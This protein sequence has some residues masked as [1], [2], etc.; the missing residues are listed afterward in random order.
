LADEAA[1]ADRHFLFS[2]HGSMLLDGLVRTAPLSRT[3]ITNGSLQVGT[4]QPATPQQAHEPWGFL[5]Q[6]AFPEKWQQHKRLAQ[7]KAAARPAAQ[8]E[9]VTEVRRSY[10][11]CFFPL[12]LVGVGDV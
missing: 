1:P 5:K 3:R 2:D 7:L 4:P 11:L 6:G 12:V 9:S 8:E 10:R